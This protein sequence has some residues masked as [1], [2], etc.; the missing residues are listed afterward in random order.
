MDIAKRFGEN[1]AGARN[2][3]GV[4]QE[5]LAFIASLHR[6]EIGMV[7]RGTRLARIDTLV[8]LA[9]A[10]SMAPG[11]LLEGITWLPGGDAAGALP[12]RRTAR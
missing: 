4:S 12:D 3:A 2:R 6:T 5:E 9:A 10:L 8:K 7:E 11:D 1:V